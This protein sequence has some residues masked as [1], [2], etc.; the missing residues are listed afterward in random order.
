MPAPSLNGHEADDTTPL[1]KHMPSKPRSVLRNFSTLFSDW[2]LWEII[3]I[4]TSILALGGIAVIFAV[5]DNSA[6]PDWPT[7]LLTVGLSW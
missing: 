2:W 7:S 1:L 5:Y 3:G 4:A 6:L